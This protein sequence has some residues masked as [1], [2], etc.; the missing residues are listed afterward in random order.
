[1]KPAS[2]IAFEFCEEDIRKVLEEHV[3]VPEGYQVTNV[4]INVDI[5][6]EDVYYGYTTPKAVFKNVTVYAKPAPPEPE[7]TQRAI[8]IH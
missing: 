8:P 7:D 3:E 2:T 4:V 1:V 5:V 6:K